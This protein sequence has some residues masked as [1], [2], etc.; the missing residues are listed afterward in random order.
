MNRRQKKVQPRLDCDMRDLWM[1]HLFFCSQ[2]Q[3]AWVPAFRASD[4]DCRGH[5]THCYFMTSVFPM[6]DDNDKGLSRKRR[7]G[8]GGRCSWWEAKSM[9]HRRAFPIGSNSKVNTIPVASHRDG[10]WPTESPSLLEWL[11]KSLCLPPGRGEK[12]TWSV[13]EELEMTD[14]VVLW[15]HLGLHVTSH[16]SLC[17]VSYAFWRRVQ[18]QARQLVR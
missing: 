18:S 10:D 11:T 14:G 16:V 15:Y 7:A 9:R 12:N 8:G 1:K 13:L 6:T 4:P 3:V 2:P 5:L 17:S